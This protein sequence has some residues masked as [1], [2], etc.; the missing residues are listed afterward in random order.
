MKFNYRART[1]EGELR[2]GAVEAATVDI[3]VSSLQ[4]RGLV[5]VSLEPEK[6]N[7]FSSGMF[8]LF[9]RVKQKDI[10]MLSRQL[11]TLFEAKVPVVESLKVIVSEMENPLLK[12][13]IATML[14]DIQGGAEISQAMA[15]HPKVFSAFYVNM[16]RSGEESGK[17]DETFIYLADYLERSY[18]LITK[19]RNA[20]IYPAF[21]LGAFVI[22]IMLMLVVI[23]PQLA[24]IL[25]EV[26]GELPIYTR[27]IVGLSD[28]MRSFGV[29]LLLIGAL[30]GVLLWRFYQTPA[31][32]LAVHRFQMSV[33]IIGTLYQRVYMARVADNLHTLLS[34][35]IPVVRALEITAEVVG[36]EVYR[37]IVLN[38]IESVKGGSSISAAFAQ[39]PDIP[40][41]MSQMMRIGEET[42]RLDTILQSLA[43]FYQREVDSLLENLVDLIEPILILVLGGGVGILVA[44]ILLPI[45]SFSTQF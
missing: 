17:L 20:M 8:R 15:R 2:N 11:A 19:A 40:P 26:G 31:G 24:P 41:L 37:T 30:V 21:V 25:K 23:I 18:E 1:Q 38:S 35:G 6:E 43:R 12:R 7:S 32:K 22:V 4:R 44:A 13:E 3:A 27:I 10:V 36:N 5:V 14:D 33:P 9:E 34:G 42:G 28:F 45:Y 16:V 29:L 39:H